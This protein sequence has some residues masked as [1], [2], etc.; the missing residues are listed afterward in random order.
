MKR[1]QGFYW[2]KFDERSK[3]QPGYFEIDKTLG[4]VWYVFDESG[5]FKE[6]ELLEIDERK[7]ERGA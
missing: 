1:E 7:I 3:W 4:P 5:W 6:D 2:V